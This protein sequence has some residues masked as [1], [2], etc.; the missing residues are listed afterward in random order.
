MNKDFLD[1][2]TYKYEKITGRYLP[3]ASLNKFYNEYNFVNKKNVGF[4][5]NGTP[6]H[7]LTLG[8][9]TTKV[10]MWSQMH[11]NESTTTKAVLDL[12][13]YLNSDTET[14]KHILEKITIYIIPML[15]P[16]GADAYTRYNANEIDLNRDSQ[17]LTQPESK[18]LRAT[19]EA[20]KPDFCFNLH[21]QRTI[22]G[23]E[24]TPY[25]ATVS[26]LAPSEDEQR[27]VTT[28]RKIAMELITYMQEAL[29]EYIP[30]QI[31][32]F[33]DGFNIN[34]IGDTFTYLGVPTILFEAGHFP[35]DYE[36]E[37]TRKYIFLSLITALDKISTQKITG[38]GFK[39]YFEIKNNKKSFF[40]ILIKNFNFAEEE[41][42]N[43]NEIGVLF[44]ENLQNNNIFLFPY[45]EKI[46]NLQS[47]YGHKTIDA[48][49]NNS[50]ITKE[51]LLTAD[52]EEILKKI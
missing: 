17:N 48:Q 14:V 25:P 51:E 46:G 3:Y 15:N 16:D 20:I 7:L 24:D 42:E 44:E 37:E 43:E 45:V 30:N 4:S 35:E 5:V 38:E 41:E 19:F 9:G 10:L 39:N 32:R 1:Y 2:S 27:T 40:D 33:D 28:T 31:A 36:R 26:F 13:S 50:K 23:V 21:D 22:F 12:I 6:I 8:R 49:F 34:C 29:A 11:G 18:V 47:F 52:I